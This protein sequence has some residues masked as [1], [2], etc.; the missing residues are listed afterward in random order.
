MKT[1]TRKTT[2]VLCASTI[3]MMTLLS[4]AAPAFALQANSPTY[5]FDKY[6]VLKDD[7]KVPNAD[8]SFTV[9]SNTTGV[10][11]VVNGYTVYAGD[12]SKLESVSDAEFTSG[13][14]TYD[15]V[16][17]GDEVKLTDPYKY[18]KSTVDVKFNYTS[19]NKPGIYRYTITE[20]AGSAYF[21][22]DTTTK[23]LDVYKYNDGTI[24]YIMHTSDQLFTTNDENNKS[25][26]IKSITNTYNTQNLSLKKSVTGNQSVNDDFFKFTVDITNLAPGAIVEATGL[27]A[28]HNAKTTWTADEKGTINA[29]VYLSANSGTAT[30]KGLTKGATYT[31]K[32]AEAA[33]KGTVSTNGYTLKAY[34]DNN[35]ATE[36]DSANGYTGTIKTEDVAETYTNDKNGTIPTGIYLNHKLAFNIVGIAAIG[37]AIS[38]AVKKHHDAAFEDEDDE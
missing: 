9:G 22:S 5:S 8:F 33:A 23:Y 19:F 10:G 26:K 3:A 15:E 17:T 21:N 20:N 2:R 37:G 35:E 38:L 6:L 34:T 31:V 13:Q 14:T 11:T 16:Q 24:T 36:V 25:T 30:L 32:E 7:A 1:R 27:D 4:T 29:E 18:A 12:T 28:D